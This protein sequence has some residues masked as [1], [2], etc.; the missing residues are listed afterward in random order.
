MNTF[1]FKNIKFFKKSPAPKKPKTNNS[2][3]EKN[4]KASLLEKLA[5]YPHLS[6]LVFV[7]AVAYLISYVPSMTLPQLTEGEIAPTDMVAPADLTIEDKETTDIRRSEAEEAV[8]PVYNLDQNVFLITEEKIREFFSSGREFSQS[9]LT[10]KQIDEFNNAT[11]EKYGFKIPTTDLRLL[12]RIKFPADLEENLISLIGKI[13]SA[14]IILTKNL[15]IHGEQEKGLTLIQA[16]GNERSIN[17]S[18]IQ[19]I[20]ESKVKLSEEIN[21]LELSSNK[22]A[23]LIVLSHLFIS[24]NISFN[25]M[26]TSVRQEAARQSIEGRRSQSGS[27]QADRDH[28]PEPQRKTQLA[29]QF[30]WIVH[31]VCSLVPGPYVLPAISV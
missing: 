5:V 15:F 2:S 19:D 25:P 1:S 22:K 10:A 9:A 20:N 21:E 29:H 8:L 7:I 26:E 11:F 4:E 28:Q 23:L 18:E 24:E 17:T 13:S 30:F 14:G 31:P 12:A 6:L 16:S 27:P 3:P